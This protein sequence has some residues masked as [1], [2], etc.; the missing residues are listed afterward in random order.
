[1]GKFIVIK[2]ADFSNVSVE[3]VTPTTL[4]ISITSAGSVTISD[5]AATAIY[6]TIDGSTPTTS[7]TQYTGAFNVSS[8]TTVKAISLYAT[9]STSVVVSKEYI[10]NPII[11]TR[12]EMD[13]LETLVTQAFVITSNTSGGH[14]EKVGN[15][16]NTFSDFS[17]VVIP[18]TGY[19]RVI[20]NGWYLKA[21][22]CFYNSN[23]QSHD[24]YVGE[25]AIENDADLSD[26][27]YSIPSGAKYIAVNLFEELHTNQTV[28]LL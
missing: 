24:Y 12:S 11:Y 3:V 2:N 22:A 13:E 19:S 4:G 15:V 6:Y 21:V 28:T 10:G 25:C 20:F 26:A 8:G 1:M 7:S 9:G 23:I 18:V 16:N 27:E 5:E 17:Y 14:P